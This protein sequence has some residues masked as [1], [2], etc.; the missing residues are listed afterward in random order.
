MSKTSDFVELYKALLETFEKLVHWTDRDRRHAVDLINKIIDA[1]E[2]SLPIGLCREIFSETRNNYVG[3]YSALQL[4]HTYTP[5]IFT[6][7]SRLLFPP[8]MWLGGFSSLKRI[9]ISPFL[10]YCKSAVTIP[11]PRLILHLATTA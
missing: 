11:L 2:I 4:S 6:M 1:L 5:R 7:A 9:E 8:T 3:S 10:Y